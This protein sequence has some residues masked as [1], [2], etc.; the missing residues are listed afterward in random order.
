MHVH[1]CNTTQ[2]DLVKV[3]ANA[4]YNCFAAQ[5]AVREHDGIPLV[6]CHCNIDHTSPFLREWGIMAVRNICAGNTANQVHGMYRHAVQCMFVSLSG[7]RY[8][9]I[10]CLELF[11]YGASAVLCALK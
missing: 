2:A 4:C 10:G 8:M 7:K 3:I 1:Y 11:V 5:E 9:C 6:L